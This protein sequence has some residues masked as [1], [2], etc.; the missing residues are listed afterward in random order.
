MINL[1]A[2]IRTI[3]NI[4]LKNSK[5]AKVKKKLDK[6]K[7]IPGYCQ[8]QLGGIT[9]V[10]G[11][12]YG[13]KI[14]FTKNMQNEL[15]ENAWSLLQRSISIPISIIGQQENLKNALRI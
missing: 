14:K 8:L 2:V 6:N 13:K 5:K 10:T 1:L 7:L 3:I 15:L 11:N 12:I 4:F 9:Q